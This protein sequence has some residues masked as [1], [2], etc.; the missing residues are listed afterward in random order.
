LGA[1]YAVAFAL[2]WLFAELF[3]VFQRRP[4]PPGNDLPAAAS[5]KV[6]TPIVPGSTPKAGPRDGD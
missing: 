4:S 5:L 2:L 3:G 6:G 1:V